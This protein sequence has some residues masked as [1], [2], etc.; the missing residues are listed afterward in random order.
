[1]RQEI[2]KTGNILREDISNTEISK[3]EHFKD[4]FERQTIKDRTFERQNI[5]K[6]DLKDRLSKTE[7]FKDRF[8]RQTV[9]DRTFERQ[10]ISNDRTFQ[11]QI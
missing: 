9:K 2:S 3:I 6:T 5:S 11:R 1:M 8:E 7:H 10:N 4:R